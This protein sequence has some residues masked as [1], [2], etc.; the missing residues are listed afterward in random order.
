MFKVKVGTRNRI[1][2]PFDCWM[3]VTGGMETLTMKFPDDLGTYE[4]EPGVGMTKNMSYRV[5]VPFKKGTN[6]KLIPSK[7]YI[8]VVK[9]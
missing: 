2:I 4:W 7:K 3:D 8:K 1:T 6:L 9:F 5:A